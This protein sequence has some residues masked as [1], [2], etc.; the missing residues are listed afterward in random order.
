MRSFGRKSSEFIRETVKKEKTEREHGILISKIRRV[1]SSGCIST[2]YHGYIS[3]RMLL[4][5]QKFG[6]ECMS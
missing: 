1:T 5:P 3:H 4:R 6:K 2:G